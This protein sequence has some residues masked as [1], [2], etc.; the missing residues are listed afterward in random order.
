MVPSSSSS[1]S[2]PPSAS[3]SSRMVFWCIVLSFRRLRGR[4]FPFVGLAQARARAAD[5]GRVGRIAKCGSEGVI[6]DRLRLDALSVDPIV[7]HGVEYLVFAR[8]T[9]GLTHDIEDEW[10]GRFLLC[11]PFDELAV[12]SKIVGRLRQ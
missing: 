11:G 10:H 2:T 3:S 1:S 9:L 12:R 6:D 8:A 5:V 7:R 4:S